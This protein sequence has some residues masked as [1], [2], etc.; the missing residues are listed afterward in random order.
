MT[1]M[2]LVLGKFPFPPDGNPL[3]PFELLQYIVNEPVPTLPPGKFSKEFEEFIARRYTLKLKMIS[4]KSLHL[5]RYRRL[6]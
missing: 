2:E 3:S 5:S 6:V 4:R 1:L